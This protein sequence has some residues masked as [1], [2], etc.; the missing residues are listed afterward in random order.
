MVQYVGI[1]SRVPPSKTEGSHRHKLSAKFRY[2]SPDLPSHILLSK[3]LHRSY[4]FVQSLNN[5]NMSGWNEIEHRI[6]MNFGSSCNFPT[7]KTPGFWLNPPPVLPVEDTWAR[8]LPKPRWPFWQR[9]GARV[10]RT[11]VDKLEKLEKERCCQLLPNI[12]ILSNS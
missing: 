9:I 7:L 4:L 3:I 12:A 10:H 2:N 8:H 11:D 5:I 1:Y 6:F